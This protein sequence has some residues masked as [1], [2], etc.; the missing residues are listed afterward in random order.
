M[1]SRSKRRVKPSGNGRVNGHG[2]ECAA[3]ALKDIKAAAG[4]LVRSSVGLLN[5]EAADQ[6][7]WLGN[8][9]EAH[10]EQGMAA[11]GGSEEPPVRGG[12]ARP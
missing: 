11:L 9:I 12:R 2:P 3:K 8:Q 10:A 5:G 4:L 1:A 7:V 6:F